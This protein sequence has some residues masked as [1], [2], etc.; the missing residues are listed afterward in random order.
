[1]LLTSLASFWHI[2]KHTKA[3]EHL[4][5]RTNLTAMKLYVLSWTG[6][7]LT[8]CFIII[9]WQLQEGDQSQK[10]LLHMHIASLYAQVVGIVLISVLNL[11][12]IYSY[13]RL[14][15]KLSVEVQQLVS[16]DLSAASQGSQGL[17]GSHL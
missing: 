12:V 15:K 7:L 13:W 16:H 2:H 11:L 17:T 6:L 8:D 4:G 3:I 9:F 1:M 5:I 10:I 14:S